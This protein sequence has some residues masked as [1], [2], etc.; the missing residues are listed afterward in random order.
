M[1]DLTRET[2]AG[3]TTL[4]IV[5]G[6]TFSFL[7]VEV[8]FGL[9]TNS[10]ALM[11]DAVHMFTDSSALA[12]SAFAAWMAKRPA[13]P[14][15]TYGYYRM[16]I[17]AALVNSVI[18]MVSALY[19]LYEAYKRFLSP[20]DVLS[21]PMMVVAFLGLVVNL[22]GVSMLRQGA[23]QNLNVQGAF[24][25]VVKDALGSVGVII[26]GLIILT[27]GWPYADPIASVLIAI[28]ILP[29]T[30]QLMTQAVD[31]LLE[32]T[33][34]RIDADE[35]RKVIEKTEGVDLVHDLHIWTITSGIISLSAHVVLKNGIDR[36]RE[37]EILTRIN[38]RIRENFDID[39]TTIQIEYQDL[40]AKEPQL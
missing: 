8:I 32:A 40:Q 3:H 37:S 27:T 28:F 1:H 18:L 16:E 12:L 10:L 25:E 22:I 36:Y 24:Y 9:I 26:A 13:T 29:R 21:I 7:I 6:L 5:A 31:I 39:H 2:G 14:E 33:P 34:S 38:Q 35:V 23:E 15:K 11:A 30:W 20:G 4:L 19:I 17:L